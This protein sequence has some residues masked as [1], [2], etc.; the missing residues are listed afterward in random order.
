M[1]R[2][3]CRAVDLFVDQ[4]SFVRGGLAN[5]AVESVSALGVNLALGSV[6][7]S[8][9]APLSAFQITD[10]PL[11]AALANNGG[12]TMTMALSAGSPAIGA[13]VFAVNQ[14]Y[15]DQRGFLRVTCANADLGA[16]R[17]CPSM[18]GTR[19]F[20]PGTAN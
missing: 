6:A 8:N 4:P 13:A 14:P 9:A 17:S 2:R 20:R 1:R 18:A 12:D 19:S 10:D 7:L 5:Q 3:G 11:L 16:R 15:H